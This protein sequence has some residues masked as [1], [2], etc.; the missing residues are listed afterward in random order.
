MEMQGLVHAGPLWSV[1]RDDA[2]HRSGLAGQHIRRVLRMGS[3]LCAEFGRHG[4][5]V[6]PSAQAEVPERKG[7]RE[8]EREREGARER[9]SEG[10]RERERERG[11]V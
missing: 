2:P 4:A 10:A 6:R 9:G 8:A 7:W 3:S 5:F 11:C 1:E